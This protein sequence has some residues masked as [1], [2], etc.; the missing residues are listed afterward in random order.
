MSV[1][2]RKEK[3]ADG[4]TRL[5]LDIYKN[6]QRTFETLSHLKLAKPANVADREN[7][8]DLLRQAEAIRVAKAAE[9][10]ANNYSLVS[11]AGKKMVVMEWLQGYVDKYT[12]KD[13]RNMQG[14]VNRFGEHLAAIKKS[15]ITF[16]ALNSE[17]IEGYIDMLN[18]SCKGEG[19]SSYY[20]RFKKA[21][22]QAY[23]RR[24]MRE[25]VF[26]FVTKKP[27]GKAAK[28]DVLTIDEVKVLA[29]TPVQSPEVRRAVI[30]SLM[31]GLRWIDVKGLKW[32]NIS[33]Q[34]K[35]VKL[36]QSKTVLEVSVPLNDAAINILGEAGTPDELVF[37]L[38][39]ANGA[40]KTL[41]AWI[42]RAGIDKKITYHNL[43]HSFGTNLIFN[44]VD[45]VT[46]SKLL[47]H[48]SLRH[49]QRYVDTAEELKIK[50]TDKLN[51]DL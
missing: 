41:K 11:D 23:R 9:L 44:D 14:A 37:N 8:K 13:K 48:T 18:D 28:K 32:A 3:N 25:N 22:K 2:L 31:S 51:F 47:G 4:T 10:E 7:N 27:R 26:D 40:N 20:S 17:I 21:I 29:V 24:L 39:G 46:A 5:R 45:V 6:G 42:K 33:V 1:K 49:T 16:S 35:V 43:R 50:A 30:F 12:K 34:Q 38:P 19:A 15:K 36:L